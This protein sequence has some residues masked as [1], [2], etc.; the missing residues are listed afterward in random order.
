MQYLRLVFDNRQDVHT[1]WCDKPAGL[2]CN[3][4]C[5]CKG[6]YCAHLVRKECK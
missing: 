3:D 5:N 2:K 4:E 6:N 1:E